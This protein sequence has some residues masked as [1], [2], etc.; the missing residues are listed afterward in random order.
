MEFLHH[1]L[2]ISYTYLCLRTTTLKPSRGPQRKSFGVPHLAMNLTRHVP[3]IIIDTLHEVNVSQQ[4][5]FSHDRQ[6]RNEHSKP[7][8]QVKEHSAR[9][10]LLCPIFTP[11]MNEDFNRD[12]DD[13]S[14][15]DPFIKYD[16]RPNIYHRDLDIFQDNKRNRLT[17]REWLAFRIQNRSCKTKTLLPLRRLFQQFLVHGY[18]MLESERL[19]W[20]HGN[21]PKLRVSKYKSL[22]EEGDQSNTHD[23]STG[24]RVF[25]PYTYVGGRRFMDQL[26]Y[27]EMTI[28]SKVGFPDLFIT[29]TCNP[30]WP[31]IQR[32]LRPLGLKSQDRPDVISRI[33]K[34]K[35]DQLL[36]YLTKKGVL[37]K[38]LAYT[39]TIEFQKRG[40][41]HA[42][43][44][45]FLHP[46]NKYLRPEDIDRIISAEV[47]DP[48]KEPKL[49]NL[50]KTHMVHWPCDWKI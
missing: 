26:Y 1:C 11:T 9:A 47:P 39:Y 43:I 16:Y 37:G 10:P 5:C 8:L 36:S 29:F 6:S 3:K 28:S 46:S 42:N 7:V 40:L 13:N 27:D 32:I 48:L 35:F 49:Y 21:Q 22:N 12:N 2:R 23:S 45:I 41:P 14:D 50:V 18:T 4:G 38:V 20:I 44:L 24:K 34:I 17:I 31:K 30:N 33:F 15:Y 25:L 19:Q